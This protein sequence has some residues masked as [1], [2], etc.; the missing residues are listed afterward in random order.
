MRVL[1]ESKGFVNAVAK[2]AARTPELK[3]MD[4]EVLLFIVF[5]FVFVIGLRGVVPGVSGVRGGMGGMGKAA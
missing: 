5:V 3:F 4:A 1:I 2:P